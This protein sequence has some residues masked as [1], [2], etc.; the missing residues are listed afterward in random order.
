MRERQQSPL[1]LV[2]R[3]CRSGAGSGRINVT[4]GTI[5]RASK[6]DLG[7]AAHRRAAPEAGSV[8][9]LADLEASH[10]V[11]ADRMRVVA[12]QAMA[13]R[14]ARIDNDRVRCEAVR[15]AEQAGWSGWL[16]LAGLTRLTCPRRVGRGHGADSNGSYQRGPND[17]AEDLADHRRVLL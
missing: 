8:T 9:L 17:R 10:V 2:V 15:R 3:Q 11:L 6:L 13:A 5:S 14:A 4:E 1:R 12:H 16:G 7:G